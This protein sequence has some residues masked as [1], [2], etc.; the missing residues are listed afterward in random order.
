M[1]AQT[2]CSAIDNNTQARYPYEQDSPC[3]YVCHAVWLLMHGECGGDAV[4][5]RDSC[6][7]ASG[8]AHGPHIAS[9]HTTEQ[10]HSAVCALP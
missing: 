6:M 8:R 3:D 9:V 5:V 1:R 2:S 4:Y 7:Q 10:L